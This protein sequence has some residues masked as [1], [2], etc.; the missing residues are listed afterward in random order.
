MGESATE[1]NGDHAGTIQYISK[2]GGG[3]CGYLLIKV[4]SQVLHT[5][6]LWH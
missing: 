6:S 3:G 5:I 2:G 4:L 1:P